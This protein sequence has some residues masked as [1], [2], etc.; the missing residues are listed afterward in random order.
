MSTM[1]PEKARQLRDG[2]SRLRPSPFAP[3]P[4]TRK[5]REIRFDLLHQPD[6]DRARELLHGLED[7]EIDSGLAPCSLSVWYDLRNYT[8]EGLETALRKQGLHLSDGI[9]CKLQHAVVYFAEETQLRN[10]R[11]PERLLKKSNAIYSKAWDRHP[12]GDH[13]ETPPDLRQDR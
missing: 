9:F 3:Q 10:M 8:L 12:H 7:L 11:G 5:H 6:V 13:D 2:G 4:G 1:S